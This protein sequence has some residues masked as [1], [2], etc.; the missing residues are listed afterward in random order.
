MIATRH[1]WLVAGLLLLALVPTYFNVYRQPPALEPGALA[2]A[3]PADLEGYRGATPGRHQAEWV[4]AQFAAQDFVERK[5][6]VGAQEL[7]IFAART[8]DGKKLFHFP[9]LALTY[10]RSATAERREEL[11]VDGRTLPVRVLEFRKPNAVH[12]SA[13]ALFYGTRPVRDP[14]PFLFRT[15][16][17]L[18]VGQ[19]EPMTLIYVQGKAHPDDEAALAKELEELLAKSAAAFLNQ[20]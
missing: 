11:D 18:V 17:A 1:A 7:E 15:L 16:P 14:M 3:I 13:S 4:A 12:R 6:R 10:G 9:E 20:P 5:Y 19:R 2:V 8:Y